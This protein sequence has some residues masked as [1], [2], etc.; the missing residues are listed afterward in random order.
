MTVNKHL[1]KLPLGNSDF[2]SLRQTGAVYVDKTE[3][4]YELVT[5][6]S[7][8]LFL[9]RPR[10]FGKSLL[11]STLLSLFKFGVKDF[12]GLKISLHWQEPT[13]KVV[14][15]DLSG[16]SHF[17]NVSEFIQYF[18]SQIRIAFG[19]VGFIDNHQVDTLE[20]LFSW[21]QDQASYSI[22]L[23]IDEYDSP[24]TS[25]LDRPLL[26]EEVRHQLNRFFSQLKSH[27]GV[28]RLMFITGITKL[29]ST[30]IFSGF[31]NLKD[32]SYQPSYS[33]LLGYTEE[34]LTTYFSDYIRRSASVLKISQC[35][36]INKL[37]EYYDGFSFD[38]EGRTHVFCP[39]SIL[40][41]FDNEQCIFENYWFR[42]GGQPAVLKNYLVH[43]KLEKP[44]GFDQIRTIFRNDLV[45]PNQYDSLS[46]DVLLTQAG[47]LTIKSGDEF[48][49]QVGYPNR[50]VRLSMANLYAQELIKV[51][52]RLSEPG[53]LHP[54]QIFATQSVDAVI[55]Q[56][57]LF[58][59]A[60]N[61]QN[62][63]I[64]SESSVCSHL[65]ALLMGA[66]LIPEVEKHNAKGRS[67]LEVNVG[68]RRWIFEF[69]FAKHSS[70]TTSLLAQAVEQIR[71]KAYGETVHGKTLIRV[72]LVFDGT[73]RQITAWHTLDNTN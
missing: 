34:E 42:T 29:S 13:Y 69:K 50:E 7:N 12:A 61:Y 2:A 20:Q 54:A 3:S 55:R 41:F 28:F 47:Y 53:G 73:E 26:L 10:R 63:P 70:E 59:N 40:S 72:A 37:R 22:V 43:H 18:Y 49:I 33:T 62:Y 6:N 36:V 65:Q 56:L 57:N 58:F 30:G 39:W 32:I 25:C 24:L 71:S 64:S 44:E 66:T 16:A 67:D 21:L 35:D 48:Q 23:L 68:M 60:I 17:N 4:I 31:N 51:G 11:V 45:N 19:P 14:R 8:F 46:L 52:Y 1:P 9:A 15:L 27:Q 5:G 38:L